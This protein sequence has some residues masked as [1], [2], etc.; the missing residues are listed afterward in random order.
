MVMFYNPV[1]CYTLSTYLLM[2]DFLGVNISWMGIA[3]S[4]MGLT[5]NSKAQEREL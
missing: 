1:N 3:T 2:D 4:Q 5:R